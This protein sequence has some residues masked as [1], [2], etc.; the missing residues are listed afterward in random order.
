MKD[1]ELNAIKSKLQSVIKNFLDTVIKYASDPNGKTPLLANELLIETKEKKL[2]NIDGN[3]VM[4]SNLSVQ[5]NFMRTLVG[6]GR[7]TGE[8][9]YLKR[10]INVY[11]YYFENLMDAYGLLRWGHQIFDL[12]KGEIT[13]L[14]EKNFVHELKNDFPFYDFM[15]EIDPQ[16]TVQYIQSVW[17]SHVYN[18]KTLEINRHSRAKKGNSKIWDQEL[19]DTP[20]F[21]ETEGLS[22]LNCGNDLIYAAIK[23]YE[24]TGENGALKWAK[25]LNN[26]Y[27]RTPH[28]KTLLGVYQ[29]TQCKKEKTPSSDNDTKSIYGDRAKRQ[30]G[31]EFGDIALEGNILFQLQECT[32]YGTN[33]LMIMGFYERLGECIKEMAYNVKEGLKSF[34]HYAYNKETNLIYPL[35]TDGTNMTNYELKR[36]GYYGAKGTKITPIEATGRFL[37]SYEYSARLMNDNE[38]WNVAASIAENMGLGDIGSYIGGPVNLNMQ[39]VCDDTGVLYSLLDLYLNTKKEDFLNL[40]IVVAENIIANRNIEGLF[41]KKAGYRNAYINAPEPLAILK[42]FAILYNAERLV[43]DTVYAG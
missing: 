18:W 38:L 9:S 10:A 27:I 8:Q 34:A 28:P 19:G 4:A 7:V 36:D 33:A 32:I 39:T 11:R 31:P 26:M 3:L 6:F 21:F 20:L 2:K 41:V 22:F 35:L 30:F 12:Q 5:Q 42:L 24:L 15:F 17:N 25:N 13:S 29:Y 43:P 16:K 37:Y 1:N 14:K 23:L 40:A